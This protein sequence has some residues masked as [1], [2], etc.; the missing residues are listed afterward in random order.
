MTAVFERFLA[1]GDSFTEGMEDERGADGRHRGW[2]DRVASALAV[3][4]PGLLYGN[5]AIRGR[6][7]DQ[8]VAEQVPAA[9][10]LRPDLVS[11]HAGANDVLRPGLDLTSLHAR[12]DDA[13]AALARTGATVVLFT[14]IQRAG[15][16]TRAAD[17]LAARFAAFNARVRRSAADHGAVLVDVGVERA[18]YDRRLWHEDRLHLAPAGHRRVAAAVLEALGVTD[19]SLLGGAA[20]WWRQPLLAT[21]RPP[22]HRRVAEDVRWAR[23]HLAPWVIR[24]VRGVSSGDG[25]APKRPELGTIAPLRSHP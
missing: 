2:A 19:P 1:L 17:R 13:V 12:Y 5:L 15:G 10:Q 3:Q 22:R 24:R 23:R 7:L 25:V 16:T 11:F 21:A 18:L 6:L 20:G 9:R 4:Q 8:V 14:A